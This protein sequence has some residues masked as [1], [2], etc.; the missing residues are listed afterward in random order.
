MNQYGA[1]AKSTND[2][3]SNS[4]IVTNDEVVPEAAEP[5]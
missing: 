5:S 2:T 1:H 4:P 3:D